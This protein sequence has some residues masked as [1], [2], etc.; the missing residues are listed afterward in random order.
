MRRLTLFI[1]CV[2]LLTGCASVRSMLPGSDSGVGSEMLDQARETKH[3]G[4][5]W[6]EGQR[7][8]EKGNKL[9]SKSE[10]LAR[11]SREVQT[12]AEDMIARGNT[13]IQS[14]EKSYE[15][16]FRESESETR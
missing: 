1:C 11:E 2:A 8:V 15:L 4:K 6:N 3:L 12:E 10:T 16:A 14:S 5:S 7:L 9:K 13:L